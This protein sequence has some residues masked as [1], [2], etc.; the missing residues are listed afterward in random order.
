MLSFIKGHKFEDEIEYV[1]R[2]ILSNEDVAIEKIAKRC[3]I[4]DK[5]GINRE[6]DVYYEFKVA[7]TI[8]RVAI[9]CKNHKRPIS[10]EIVDQF[11]G[12]LKDFNNIHGCIISKNG[13]QK[14]AAE[15]AIANGI[16]LIKY[17]TLP[18]FNQILAK[19]IQKVWLPTNETIGR[20]FYTIME[21][22]DGISTT[23]TYYTCGGMHVLLFICKNAA[24][25]Y[26]EK[27][28]DKSELGVFGMSKEQLC[29]LCMLQEA[30]AEFKL[31]IVPVLCL[32]EETSTLSIEYSG[33]SIRKAFCD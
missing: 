13:Y 23:G 2:N 26:L 33:E 21:K 14:G 12:K 11:I 22:D 16:E 19:K 4:E 18:K 17:D 24:I 1:Y 25:S 9:E 27:L 8:H 3:K 31:A 29:A 32:E 7:G 5:N 15:K 30:G 6:F 20:P 10:I 28:P